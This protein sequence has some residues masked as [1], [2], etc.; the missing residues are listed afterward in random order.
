MIYAI[1]DTY[2]LA[3]VCAFSCVLGLAVSQC[4]GAVIYQLTRGKSVFSAYSCDACGENIKW[5]D[6]IPVLS[7][8]FLGG[9]C[10]KCKAPIPKRYP[11]IELLTAALFLSSSIIYAHVSIFYALTSM[12]VCSCCI[13]VFF[14]DLDSMIINNRFVIIIAFCGVLSVFFEPKCDIL[15]RIIGGIAGFLLFYAVAIVGSKLYKAEAMGGGDIKLAL[16]SGILLGWQKLI[17]MVLIASISGAVGMALQNKKDGEERARPFGPYL[18]SG[19]VIAMLFGD[20]L[21]G[22]Y[23]AL[24]F[25]G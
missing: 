23:L 19:L 6:C 8:L 18:A 20:Y 16:A 12:I 2:A 22:A 17:V 9:K 21:T 14:I 3:A 24:I 25:G 1:T 5:Y 13:C 4:L 7:Y 11:L 15:S 10:R